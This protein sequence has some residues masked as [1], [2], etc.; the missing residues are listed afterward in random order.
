MRIVNL[1]RIFLKLIF[2]TSILIFC[3][4]TL[5]AQ[6]NLPQRTITVQPTQA[7]DFGTF[8]VISAGTIT[9]DWQGVVSTTGGVVSLS[10]AS[11]RP[12]IFDIKLCQGR[13]VT[14]TYNPTSTITNG[15]PSLT[16]NIGP[17]EKGP[18]GSTFTVSSDCNFITTLRVGGTL[19][20]P[21]GTPAG[22]YNGSFS[23]TFTQQ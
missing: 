16:L 11:A 19:D 13:N 18:S 17:T 2:L 1:N 20:V 5:H 8:Y 3:L 14:I 12:A 23:M 7:I 6:P 22:I 9:V 10:V 21:G 15:V 4:S